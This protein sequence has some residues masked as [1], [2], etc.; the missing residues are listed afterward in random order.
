MC[1]NLGIVLCFVR[2]VFFF[3]M[4]LL[5]T[6]V[7]EIKSIMAMAHLFQCDLDFSAD[8]WECVR[9]AR[10]RWI[11]RAHQSVRVPHRFIVD[12]DLRG[13]SAEISCVW[14]LLMHLQL[15][16]TPSLLRVR[17]SPPVC[18]PVCTSSTFAVDSHFTWQSHFPF[19]CCWVLVC[20][21]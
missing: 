5:R 16:L 19:H 18:L 9:V 11:V 20:G 6:F 3:C 2:L 4:H 7:I 10:W 13:K 12:F 8:L 17:I 14:L 15:Q 21:C 1:V